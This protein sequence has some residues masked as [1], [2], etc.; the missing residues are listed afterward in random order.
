[1]DDHTETKEIGKNLYDPFKIMFKCPRSVLKFKKFIS[2]IYIYASCKYIFYD[3][4]ALLL[5]KIL[6]MHSH[7]SFYIPL[8]NYR[9]ERFSIL[10]VFFIFDHEDLRSDNVSRVRTFTLIKL[11]RSVSSKEKT[12]LRSSI[13]GK[14]LL[15]NQPCSEI[16]NDQRN[17]VR[18]KSNTR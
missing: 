11:F 16:L 12:S 5:L 9:D 17:S 13:K 10:P 15:R 14:I 18:I 6:F 4:N 2:Y 1:M 8:S 3:I 7:K